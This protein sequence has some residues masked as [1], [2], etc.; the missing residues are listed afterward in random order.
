M[1][2]KRDG[3]ESKMSQSSRR[4]IKEM[5]SDLPFIVGGVLFIGDSLILLTMKN[6]NNNFM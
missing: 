2:T 5:Q 6:N 4:G 1:L 3:E